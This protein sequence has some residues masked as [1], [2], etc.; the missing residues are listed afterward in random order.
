VAPA[1]KATVAVRVTLVPAISTLLKVLAGL[2]VNEPTAGTIVGSRP[3]LYVIVSF[4]GEAKA[5]TAELNVGSVASMKVEM[6]ALQA[7]K[8]VVRVLACSVL[9]DLRLAI[10]ST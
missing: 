10:I 9:P 2:E 5:I 1:A 6:A 7:V 3:S 4:V 8:N